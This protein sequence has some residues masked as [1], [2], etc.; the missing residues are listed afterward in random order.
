MMLTDVAYIR[1][2]NCFDGKWM[3]DQVCRDYRQAEIDIV[4]DAP[5]IPGSAA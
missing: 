3:L 5:P 2:D 4:T 1:A